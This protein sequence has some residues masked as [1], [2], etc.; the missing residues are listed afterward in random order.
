LHG[1]LI[2]PQRK[3]FE[4][5]KLNYRDETDILEFE[6][7]AIAAENGM[8]DLHRVTDDSLTAE[9]QRMIASFL[10]ISGLDG[11][12]TTTETVECMTF[13]RLFSRHRV[14][15]IDLLQIDVEGYDYELLKLLDFQIMKP[16]LIRYEHRH[17]SLSD[18]ASCRK[19]LGYNGYRLLPMK[20]DT[21]A[22][23]TDR[24]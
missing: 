16:R 4:R 15:R 10:P 5:L 8:R 9:W 21:G 2:E 19:Y 6:N 11:V 12:N 17:L 13:D 20:Y 14:K 7:V 22:V 1:V 3:E 18:I 23:L 24:C